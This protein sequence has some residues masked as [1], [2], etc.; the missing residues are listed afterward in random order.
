M[1]HKMI[2]AYENR[3]SISM[4]DREGLNIYIKPN[5]LGYHSVYSNN[6]PSEFSDLL[7]EKEDK[8]F[9]YHFGVNPI[10]TL[11]AF[12][13]LFLGKD[14]L[15]S[16]TL[17]QQLAKI[18]LQNESERS[19]NNKLV[20]TVYAINL[21]LFSSKEDVL[22]MYLNSV[23]L[24][25]NVQGINQ[26]S[27]LYFDTTP[28]LLTKEQSL[29]L[30]ATLSN[31]S[32][33]HP[34]SANNALAANILAEKLQENAREIKS[35]ETNEIIQRKEAFN[36]YIKN[37]TFF[38]L[39]SFGIECQ[40]NCNLTIDQDLSMNSR[41]ILKRNLLLLDKKSVTNGA[42]VIIKLPENELL[43]IIGSP[44]PEVPSY[45]YQINMA[46]KPRP[47][48]STVKPFIYLKGFEK[49]LRPYTI[50][51]D[52]E[53]K[54]TIGTGFSF[55]PKNYD[56]QY[57]GKVNLH[58]ALTNSLNVPSVKVLEYAGIDNFN[59]FLLDDLEFKPVQ[60]I[61]NYQLGIALGA[62]EM[63]LTTL[64]YY[65][66]IFPNKGELKPLKI[67]K[68]KNN[69]QTSIDT[70][71]SQKKQ[72]AEKKYIQLINKITSDRNTGIE[73]FGIKSNLNISKDN[74]AVKTG[75]SRE[76]HDSWTIGYTPDFLVGVWVGNSDNT[77]M[78][79][80][81]GQSGAGRIWNE[82]M[83]LLINSNYNKNSPL[84]FDLIKEY[85]D[86][87][88]IEYGLLDDDF[89]KSKYLLENNN[90][91]INPHD[92][93]V[94]LLEKDTRIPLRARENVKWFVNDLFWDNNSELNFK[95]AKYGRYEIRAMQE[96][97]TEETV[98]IYIEDEQ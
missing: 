10:S 82:I 23:Y 98:V 26:A 52:K 17:T 92:G 24:G 43:S 7:L 16:S 40:I 56:Y 57:R 75:T 90:L 4:Q 77:P 48:G 63:D 1:N 28:H 85:A 9:Y 72:I 35:F 76:Y 19:I 74:Y 12:Y 71:F 20:E 27:R 41:E 84:N 66:T 31:P 44:Q 91:I 50:V 11:R 45:G 39:E 25:N 73:Q 29:Q 51:E 21:E 34:F 94:F 37:N 60:D 87:N 6:I 13:N 58:Y 36:N 83:N 5:H 18:L 42:I 67:Y 78:E 80:I 30:L 53:Y 79:N 8:Y 55:Y 47:I 93:D 81:S 2:L 70:N 68:D 61:E 32:T 64:S 89:E 54:Y 95:P 49:Q 69:F 33:N 97:G 14:N 46:I 96:N 62:L 65:F 86:N 22:R 3:Q 59:N 15:A 38:E 88:T